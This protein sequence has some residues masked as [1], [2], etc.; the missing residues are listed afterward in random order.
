MSGSSTS[1]SIVA[2][3]ASLP[4]W[5]L[6][7]SFNTTIVAIH[8]DDVIKE[9]GQSSFPQQAGFSGHRRLS[10]HKPVYATQ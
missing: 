10:T 4:R 3:K 2:E 9:G 8:T 7:D 6:V 5:R 1:S